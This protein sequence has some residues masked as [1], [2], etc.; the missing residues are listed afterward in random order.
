MV[1][2][3]ILSVMAGMAWKGVDGMVKARD[4]SEE[5]L[6]RTLRL[7][8]VMAQIQV[9]LA[10]VTDTGIVPSVEFDGA[11]LRLTRAAPEGGMMV[12]AWGLRGDRWL[13]WASPPAMS[14]AALEQQWARTRTLQEAEP[15]VL[16]V[17]QGVTQ[18]QVY[19]HRGGA[20]SN[21]QSSAGPGQGASLGQALQRDPA[22][23]AVRVLITFD[24]SSGWEGAI[25]RDMLV[26]RQ[27]NQN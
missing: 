24:P 20:W 3:L 11:F 18:W 5:S 2:L 21:A 4:V 7:Q 16:T 26:A 19:F 13:R 6:R 27:P 14:V 8:S 23:K 12:V 15:G 9:D 22:P 25:S 10:A 17:L 1:A